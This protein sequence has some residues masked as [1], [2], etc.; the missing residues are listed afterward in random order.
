MRLQQ[1]DRLEPYDSNVV[2]RSLRAGFGMS[3]AMAAAAQLDFLA[4]RL[5][6]EARVAAIRIA[7]LRRGVFSA[8]AVTSLAAHVRNE[9]RDLLPFNLSPRGVTADARRQLVAAQD[10]AEML[11]RLPGQL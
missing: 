8:R 1:A 2:R 10:L 6:G 4:R 7:F 9:I 3:Q 11:D 5:L